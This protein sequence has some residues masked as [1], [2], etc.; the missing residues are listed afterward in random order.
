MGIKGVLDFPI[1]LITLRDLSNY[2]HCH[3]RRKFVMLTKVSVNNVV[4]VELT[5][6]KSLKRLARSIVTSFVEAFH[7]FQQ[8]LVLLWIG[9]EFNHQ[10]LLH[11][12]IVEQ[13]VLYVKDYLERR[14]SAIP[15]SPEGG[16]LLAER[17]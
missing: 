13:Y 4:Q 2:S 15:L 11:I 9:R 6:S 12:D 1:N 5:V 16:S 3:L 17:L 14:I 8:S 10:G 7:C